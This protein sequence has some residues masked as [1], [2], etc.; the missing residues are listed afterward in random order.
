VTAYTCVEGVPFELEGALHEPLRRAISEA[1]YLIAPTISP[2]L[3]TGR[4]FTISGI[5][6]SLEL[7]PGLLL[8]IV[9]K[10]EP[11]EDWVTA[12][13]DLLL[14]ATR[15]SV[16]GDRRGGLAR[17]Q[18]PLEVLG[19]IYA[20][21]LARA[22]RRDGPLLMMERRNDVR[23]LLVG[24]LDVTRWS[25]TAGWRPQDL[26]T[27][28]QTLSA[29]NHFTRA[30]SRVA[31]V[32]AYASS[33]PQVRGRL[34]RLSQELRPGAPLDF[35]LDA[36]VARRTLPSQWTVYAGAWDIAV[37]V[38]SR[39]SLLGAKGR[40]Q[41]VSLAIEAWPLLETMLARA[42]R[43]AVRLGRD[44]GRTMLSPAKHGSELIRPAHGSVGKRRGVEPDGRL[45]EGEA[46]IAVF[47]AKYSRGQGTDPPRQHV[48]QT[49]VTAAAC[50]APLA[51][52]VYPDEFEPVGWETRGFGEQPRRLVSI[53]L[54][55]FG[56]RRG[57]GDRRRGQR[58]F[59]LLEDLAEKPE[60]LLA[61]TPR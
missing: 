12:A 40:R 10:T 54:G 59:G 60:G 47:E 13:L 3:Q 11:E 61:P 30:M 4:L 22:L 5:I 26:P 20:E 31:D 2:L 33:S 14:P 21:R 45:V 50:G 46:T 44:H 56:Y 23:Q 41:G 7:R 15:T 49:L 51:V 28:F 55:L 24:K 42:L 18:Q 48:F 1:K 32:L 52:L 53:G 36:A 16:A 19:A 27:S 37:S 8:E 17:S 25:R 39:K 35:A 34:L 38:L 9:P 29:D 57:E 58:L 43:Q 6:G